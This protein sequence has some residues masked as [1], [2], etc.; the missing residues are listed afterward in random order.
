VLKR[1]LPPLKVLGKRYKF[2]S[3]LGDRRQETGDRRQKAKGKR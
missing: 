1:K 2:P 3:R